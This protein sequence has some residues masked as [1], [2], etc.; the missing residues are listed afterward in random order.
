MGE[1]QVY[2]GDGGAQEKCQ[3]CVPSFFSVSPCLFQ[4][5]WLN[6]IDFFFGRMSGLCGRRRAQETNAKFAHRSSLLPFP[7][8]L[9][10]LYRFLLRANVK[11]MRATAGHKRNIVKFASFFSGSPCLFQICWLNI[12]DLFF[13]QTLS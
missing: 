2:P 9:A 12:I 5:H 1:R 13:W 6:S 4:I 8:L 10:K 3:V 11:S 7:N